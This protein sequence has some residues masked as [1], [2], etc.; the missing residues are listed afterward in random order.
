MRYLAA[1]DLD[2]PGIVPVDQLRTAGSTCDHFGKGLTPWSACWGIG[3]LEEHTE[4][5]CA[6]VRTGQHAKAWWERQPMGR[7]TEADDYYRCV[8][9]TSQGCTEIRVNQRC[10]CLWPHSEHDVVGANCLRPLD[11]PSGSVVNH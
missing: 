2:D 6:G 4:A 7:T 1:D 8:H 3:R 5:C 10:R 11:P 9:R